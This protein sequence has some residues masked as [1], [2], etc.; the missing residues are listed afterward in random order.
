M[1]EILNLMKGNKLVTITIFAVTIVVL[2]YIVFLPQPIKGNNNTVQS[3]AT[4]VV[5]KD[6]LSG[7]AVKIGDIGNIAGD[8]NIGR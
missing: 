5:S 1:L 7:S 8:L 2:L 3:T 6:T 4:A